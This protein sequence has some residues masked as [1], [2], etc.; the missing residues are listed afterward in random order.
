MYVYTCVTLVKSDMLCKCQF[1]YCRF[2]NVISTRA[3]K[4]K[5][6]IYIYYRP[7]LFECIRIRTKPFCCHLTFHHAIMP[8]SMTAM[9]IHSTCFSHNFQRCNPGA[10]TAVDTILDVLHFRDWDNRPLAVQ[11]QSSCHNPDRKRLLSGS[12]ENHL[13]ES[14]DNS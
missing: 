3:M 7:T 1:M 14:F 2:L 11:T 8:P 13:I 9:Y 12:M 5:I 4:K 6:Y 10:Y